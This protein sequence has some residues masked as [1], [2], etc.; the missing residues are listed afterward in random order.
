MSLKV[1][2][3]TLLRSHNV[4]VEQKECIQVR[5]SGVWGYSE[6]I[7]H[8][9]KVN[10]VGLMRLEPDWERRRGHMGLIMAQLSDSEAVFIDLA[11]AQILQTLE[12]L[13]MLMKPMLQ[14]ALR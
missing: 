2:L 6:E 12:T 11:Q 5:A 1:P 4:N 13:S 14:I 9:R 7:S 3:N 8:W 10:M